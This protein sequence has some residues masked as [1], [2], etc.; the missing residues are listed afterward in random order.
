MAPLQHLSGL[1][2]SNRDQS[3]VNVN[4]LINLKNLRLDDCF[5]DETTAT[6]MAIH[7]ESLEQFHH[8]RY[9]PEIQVRE[10]I[11]PFVRYAKKLTEM[12][13]ISPRIKDTHGD[14]PKLNDVRRKLEGASK[15]IIF[16]DRYL[17][18]ECNERSNGIDKDSLD[19]FPA[20]VSIDYH[21]FGFVRRT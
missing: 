6:T 13:I 3:P 14:I 19:I 7:L 16:I 8:K 2:L 18:V 9:H 12:A 5:L 1:H 21:A 11:K 4:Q 15:L 10:C 17:F 20:K